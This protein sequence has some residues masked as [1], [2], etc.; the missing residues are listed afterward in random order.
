MIL[1]FLLLLIVLAALFQKPSVGKEHFYGSFTPLAGAGVWMDAP[2]CTPAAVNLQKDR[3]GRY[4]GWE[5]QKSCAFVE[6][7]DGDG[8]GGIR[9]G[10]GGGG[11]GGSG[12]TI[13]LYQQCGGMGGSCATDGQCVDADWTGK[14]CKSNN[15]K[16]I[17][18][19]HRQ[20]EP[21]G[22]GGGGGGGGSGGGG[23][24]IELYGQ[25]GG[26]GGDC[27][28][29]GQCVDGPYPGKSCKSGSCQR[30]DEWYH[31]CL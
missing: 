26:K 20:C 27:A 1:I 15:C 17:N 31:Q 3:N 22:G 10:G 21:S 14:S 13:E 2:K 18:E 30:K 28:T 29:N 12:G 23:G 19:W 8:S 25:C 7:G 6:F 4:W 16:R 5:Q 11:G 24:T 9:G